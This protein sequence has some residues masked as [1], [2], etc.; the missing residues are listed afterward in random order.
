M[1]ANVH[2]SAGVA[3]AGQHVDFTVTGQNAGASGTCVPVDCKSNAGGIV[4]FTYTDANGAG[5]DTIKAS[6]TDTAGS[7]QAATAQKHWVASVVRSLAVTI[8]GTGS[9]SS[10]PGGIACPSTC[11][12]SFPDASSVALNPIPGAGFTFAGWSGAC[13][14]T[15]ACN[16]TMSADKTV[17]ATFTASV[18]NR[19][20]TVTKAGTGTG[21]VSSTPSGINCGAT[22]AASFADGTAVTLTATPTAGS[23]FTGWSGACT[24]SGACSGTMSADR[25]SRPRSPPRPW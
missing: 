11:T 15:G 4:T 2:T 12:G 20:L 21:T 13:T 10:T 19:T 17:T 16:V 18:V 5:D 25:P 14:G 9:V 7:L 3:V 1:T 22:C 8:V 24:G 6:F 23:T